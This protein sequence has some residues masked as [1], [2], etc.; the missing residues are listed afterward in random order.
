MQCGVGLVHFQFISLIAHITKSRLVRE[1]QLHGTF[2]TGSDFRSSTSS[3]TWNMWSHDLTSPLGPLPLNYSTCQSN[4]LHKQTHT[5]LD[6]WWSPCVA[7]CWQVWP[8][9]L[10]TLKQKTIHS[11]THD[12]RHTHTHTHTHTHIH[13]HTQWD[14]YRDKWQSITSSLHLYRTR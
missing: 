2:Q 4:Q 9:A 6:C 11:L 14:N 7:V 12:G 13:T 10:F 8:L 3:L 1:Q 5:W